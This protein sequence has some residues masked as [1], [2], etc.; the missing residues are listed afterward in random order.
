VQELLREGDH[1]IAYTSGPSLPLDNLVAGG[2]WT[3]A[4][5]PWREP[6]AFRLT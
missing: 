1:I 4:A 2:A 5:L 3:T 6:S